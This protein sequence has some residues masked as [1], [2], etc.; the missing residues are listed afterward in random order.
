MIIIWFLILFIITI[1][2]FIIELYN[3]I[4]TTKN[5]IIESL[6]TIDVILQNRYDLIPNIVKVAKQYAIYEKDTLSKIAELRQ[7]WLNQI[8]QLNQNKINNEIEISSLINN[9]FILSENYPTLKSDTLF[10]NIQNQYSEIEDKLQAARRIY[11]SNVKIL[12]NKKQQIPTN[13][14]AYF[15]KIENYLM[16]QVNREVN[17]S[18]NISNN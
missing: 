17:L 10:L 3:N 5:D 15:M 9:V 7:N 4:I 14:V 18:E 12:K 6:A 1:V 13:F 16:F 8:N 2:F 11:N